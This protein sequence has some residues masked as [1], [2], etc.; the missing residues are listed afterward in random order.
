MEITPTMKFA[1]WIF[2]GLEKKY[3]DNPRL[4]SDTVFFSKVI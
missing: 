2:W 1:I 3:R 4:L